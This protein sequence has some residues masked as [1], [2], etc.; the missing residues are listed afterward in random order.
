MEK[1]FEE[2][3]EIILFSGK[4][5]IQEGFGVPGVTLGDRLVGCAFLSWVYFQHRMSSMHKCPQITESSW[6]TQI[7]LSHWLQFTKCLLG[8]RKFHTHW[9]PIAAGWLLWLASTNC[10][11]TSAL[12]HCESESTS[13]PFVLGLLLTWPISGVQWTSKLQFSPELQQLHW[14]LLPLLAPIA[15]ATRTSLHWDMGLKRTKSPQ[16]T[17]NWHCF[18]WPQTHTE[19]PSEEEQPRRMHLKSPDRHIQS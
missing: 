19:S 5:S 10:L 7:I 18:S 8:S 13:W 3:K 16:L 6:C 17:A 12:T 2:E 14:L 15:S 11:P 9:V 4:I 1:L